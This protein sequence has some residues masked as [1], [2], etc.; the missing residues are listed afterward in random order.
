MQWEKEVG[1]GNMPEGNIDRDVCSW[2]LMCKWWRRIPLLYPTVSPSGL[3]CGSGVWYQLFSSARQW[4]TMC[5]PSFAVPQYM[6]SRD[7]A[8][9]RWWSRSSLGPCWY[10]PRCRLRGSA[11]A[12]PPFG[13]RSLVC[14]CADHE[15]YLIPM[16]KLLYI[17]KAS[18][19]A[20]PASFVDGKL[21][22]LLHSSSS[23]EYS[24]WSVIIKGLMSHE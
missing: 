4:K 17:I 11:S 14:R 16:K 2:P 7:F 6:H 5:L 10:A 9:P 21:Q 22:Y 23:V 1:I 18:N 12:N 20:G 13:F 3:P 15:G 8:F 24:S 19:S